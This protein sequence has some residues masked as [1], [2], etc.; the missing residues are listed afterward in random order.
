MTQHEHVILVDSLDQPIGTAEKLAAHQQGELH[1]AISVCII[2]QH[3][4]EWQLLLQ[5]RAKTKYHSGGLWSNTCCSH[6][7]PG[8]SVVAAAKRR[9]ME[10]M[11]V[12][13][14]LASIGSFIYKASLD[15]GL[16]EHELD[17]VLIGK[18]NHATIQPN[19]AEVMAYRWVNLS[20][21][22]Q[23]LRAQPQ[24]FTAWLSPIMDFLNKAIAHEIQ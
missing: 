20:T 22:A 3:E 14:D 17:H 21:L 12:D 19:P 15:N 6:P 16:I 7:R 1:R 8:E 5:Q 11:G 24:L 23:E 13:A 18:I 2:Q 4:G 9:L 10:E